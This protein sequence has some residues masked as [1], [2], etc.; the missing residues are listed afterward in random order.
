MMDVKLF[1]VRDSMTCISTI[2]IK[3]H[4]RDRHEAFVLSHAGYGHSPE[5]YVLFTDLNGSWPLSYDPYK[6]PERRTMRVAHEYVR[7]HWDELVSGQVIDV[8]YILGETETPCESD[9]FA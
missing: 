3:P 1:E 7:E 8:E 9:Q 2:A 5:L 4:A 6:Q